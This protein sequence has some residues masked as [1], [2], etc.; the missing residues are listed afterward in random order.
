MCQCASAL[1][2]CLNLRINTSLPEGSQSLKMNSFTIV[3]SL[4][5][6]ENGPLQSLIMTL[7]KAETFAI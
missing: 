4:E 7:C 5:T 1:W 2:T 6:V 3:S